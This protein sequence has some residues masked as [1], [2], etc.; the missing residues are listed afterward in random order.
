MGPEKE[1]EV[2]DGEAR[3]HFGHR[4][5]YGSATVQPGDLMQEA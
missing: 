1:L 5:T 4:G 2:P 3:S